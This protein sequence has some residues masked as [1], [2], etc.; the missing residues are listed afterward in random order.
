MA[1]NEEY[2]K[3]YFEELKTVIDRTEYD[4]INEVVA[5]LRDTKYN[6]GRLFII[7]VG[8]SAANASHAVNDFRKICGIESY[9]PV[10]NVSELTARIN[11]NGWNTCFSDWLNVSNLSDIDTLMVLSVGGGDYEN[12]ISVNLIAAIAYAK[13]CKSGVIGIVGKST[14]YT[15]KNADACIIIPVEN[16]RFRTPITEAMQSVILH[17]ICNDPGLKND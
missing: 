14:G 15:A 8:G 6:H 4:E 17:M 3:R 5:I 16:E 11:D 9:S 12:K 1:E 7:G 13:E 2:F 10:D